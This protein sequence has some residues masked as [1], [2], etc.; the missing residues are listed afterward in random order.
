MLVGQSVWKKFL[1]IESEKSVVSE[2]R[3]EQKEHKR[4]VDVSMIGKRETAQGKIDKPKL[5]YWLE[6]T[7]QTCCNQRAFSSLVL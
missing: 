2:F 6:I 7:G 4:M 5:L 1:S 3:K